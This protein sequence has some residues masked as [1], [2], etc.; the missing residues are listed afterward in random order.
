MTRSFR[1]FVL[2]ILILLEVSNGKKIGSAGKSEVMTI[3]EHKEWKKLLRTRLNVLVL[4]SFGDQ[5]V[6]SLMPTYNH[7]ATVV[8]GKGT[9]LYIDCSNAK[10]L[11]STL[12][13]KP[14]TF[15]LKHYQDGKFHKDYD[16]SFREKSLLSFMQDPSVDPPW[17]ED[18]T[19]NDVRHVDNPSDFYKLISREKIILLMFYAPWCGHCKRF[20]PEF[21]AAATKLKKKAVLA[22]MDVDKPDAFT[23]R[24]EYNISGFPTVLYFEDGIKKYD[25]SGGRD[26]EGI[27]EWMNNPQPPA[28]Q[29]AQS[30]AEVEWS[31][32]ATN[33]VHLN[34]ENFGDTIS[35][36]ANVL[37]MF[38][39]PWCG[40]C[41]AMKPHFD[42]AAR[43]MKEEQVQGVMA[44]VDATKATSLAS[45][46]KVEG[47]PTVKFFQYGEYRYE[48][49]FPRTTEAL[50]HFMK[51]PQEPPPPEKDWSEIPSEVKH[52]TEESFKNILKKRKHSLVMFYTPWCGHCKATKPFFTE[53]AASFAEDR[54]IAF[55]AVDCTK[56]T[57][58]CTSNDV[59]GYPTIKYF[60]YGKNGFKYMGPRTTESFTDFMNSPA[61][62]API[63]KD[64]L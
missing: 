44:A 9:L 49:G 29:P 64:E 33:V 19:A 16:R 38:Y 15:E 17:S 35:T 22:A 37:V 12:K 46:Y 1:L 48:Y 21:A 25:Y 27:I 8:K 61:S 47:F 4:F 50:V 13:V 58:L 52:L 31:E 36:H 20:K 39:A 40:H 42:E 26:M 30:Q 41:K 28:E 57:T 32:Q 62:Y 59:Q 18:V 60:N 7:V 6:Q 10:K 55:A 2:L 43:I 14:T 3:T 54:K 56:H 11:C 45:K 51:D 63:D 24:Q 5:H 34:E 53:A 23:I